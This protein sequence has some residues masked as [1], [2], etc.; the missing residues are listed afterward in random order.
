MAIRSPDQGPR[1]E[2]TT[3]AKA[4]RREDKIKE[5]PQGANSTCSFVTISASFHP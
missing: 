5:E 3:M 2:G 4:R 1:V